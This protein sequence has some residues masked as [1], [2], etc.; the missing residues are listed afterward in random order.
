MAEKRA[1]E[2]FFGVEDLLHRGRKISKQIAGD[3]I[4]ASSPGVGASRGML[5]G[6]VRWRRGRPCFGAKERDGSVFGSFWSG[7]GR[8]D[9]WAAVYRRMS[10]DVIDKGAAKKLFCSLCCDR[11]AYF[12]VSSYRKM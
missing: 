8:V 5:R 6:P 3:G 9:V 2:V 1:E 12:V 11:N 7:F 4:F 10:E